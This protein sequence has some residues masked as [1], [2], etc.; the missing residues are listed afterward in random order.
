[1]L[2]EN[3]IAFAANVRNWQG[4]PRGSDY[5][6]SICPILARASAAARNRISSLPD[7]NYC[8]RA[9]DRAKACR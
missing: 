2:A 6:Y 1:L 5:R 9:A 4:A 7:N 8:E 3:T